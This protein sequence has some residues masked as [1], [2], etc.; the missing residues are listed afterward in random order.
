M[1]FWQPVRVL[2][3]IDFVILREDFRYAICEV[4]YFILLNRHVVPR[5]GHQENKSLLFA[6]CASK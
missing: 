6:L 4:F 5:S 1:V 2:S 3:I